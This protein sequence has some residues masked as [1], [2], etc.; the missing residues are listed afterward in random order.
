MAELKCFHLTAWVLRIRDQDLGH[1][2]I[3]ELPERMEYCDAIE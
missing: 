2:C 3:N 1:L